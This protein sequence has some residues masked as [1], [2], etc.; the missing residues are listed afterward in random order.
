MERASVGMDRCG[1][2]GPGAASGACVRYFVLCRST[3]WDPGTTT[4]MRSSFQ[5]MI[6]GLI[7][8]LSTS[9]IVN[10]QAIQQ[11][12]VLAPVGAT[13]HMRSLQ[14]IPTLPVDEIPT[15]WPFAEVVGNDVFGSTFSVLDPATVPEATSYPGTDRVMRELRDDNDRDT[16]TF[17]DVQAQH[18]LALASHDALVTTV[19]SPGALVAAYP[20]VLGMA[21][22]GSDC[23]T[24]VSPTSLTPYCGETEI[25]FLKTGLLQLH[26]GEFDE[27]RL[28]RTRRIKVNQTDQT[29]STMTETL[30]WF[31]PGVPYPLLQLVT[32]NYANGDQARSGHILDET[33][34]VGLEELGS[35]SPLRVFPVPSSGD[36]FL[37]ATN[38][39]YLRIFAS[40][41][42]LVQQT[43]LAASATPVRL[44]MGDRSRGVYHAVLQHNGSIE[45]FK[46]VLE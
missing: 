8:L 29:D 15:I 35:A 44:P 36:V 39:G 27:A 5:Y 18:C 45:R 14:S 3:V 22:T 17:L 26:F 13:W 38:G 46:F 7:G 34:V 24:S 16:Y 10:A 20:L 6:T 42:R 32:V 4:A 30:T 25:I 21:V 33:S 28:V 23:S 12:D 43:R 37:D 31:A 1:G 2:A 11:G 9:S 19:Y 40:D 41:G